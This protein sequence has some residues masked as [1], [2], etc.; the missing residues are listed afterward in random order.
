MISQEFIEHLLDLNA[1]ERE[2]QRAGVTARKRK[3]F[4][5]RIAAL[6][7]GLPVALVSHHERM[8][9]SKRES[10]VAVSDTASCGGCHMRLP[11]G[12]LAELHEPGRIGVCPHCGV[13]V[14]R[15]AA[16]AVAA[17]GR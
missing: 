9:R 12:M 15:V 7:D 4:E 8:L 6:K 2:L 5:G 1:C 14:F 16:P 17:G 13:L 3:D 11:V 10:M